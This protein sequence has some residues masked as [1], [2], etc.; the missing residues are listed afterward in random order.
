MK[1]PCTDEKEILIRQSCKFG[2]RFAK[3]RE[4]LSSLLIL[5]THSYVSNYKTI[6]YAL[7]LF[8]KN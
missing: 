2:V 7:S 3:S 8:I 5:T 6:S 1:A 4:Y